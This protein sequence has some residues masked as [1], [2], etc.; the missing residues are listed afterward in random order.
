[1]PKLLETEQDFLDLSLGVRYV[2]TLLK[3]NIER[4]KRKENCDLVSEIVIGD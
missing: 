3:T 1:V 4:L 2:L